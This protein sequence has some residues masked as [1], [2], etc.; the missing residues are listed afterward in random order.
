MELEGDAVAVAAE[1]VRV[2]EK[3]LRS[4]LALNGGM[5]CCLAFSS[6]EGKEGENG[7][8]KGKSEGGDKLDSKAGGDGPGVGGKS[9]KVAVS[10]C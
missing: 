1:I 7:G 2:G 5:I 3:L 4:Y 6:S 10:P 9:E 8:E